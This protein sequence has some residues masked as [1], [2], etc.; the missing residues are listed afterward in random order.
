MAV[1]TPFNQ[2]LSKNRVSIAPG[3]GRASVVGGRV[4]PGGR[5]GAMVVGPTERG[6]HDEGEQIGGG[7]KE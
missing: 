2:S 4:A 7:A 1:Y 5:E 6:S 3:V